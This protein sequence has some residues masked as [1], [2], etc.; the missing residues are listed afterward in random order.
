MLKESTEG[1]NLKSTP[2]KC[3]IVSIQSKVDAFEKMF[4]FDQE[5][6]HSPQI[7][8]CDVDL[9]DDTES[10]LSQNLSIH[11]YII[12]QMDGQ[13]T[14]SSE[15]KVQKKKS[16]FSVN[17]GLNEITQLISFFRSFDNVWN[18]LD[19][20]KI[21]AQNHLLESCFFCYMRSSCLRLNAVR[22]LGPK[23]LKINEFTSQLNQYQ[24]VLGWNWHDHASN[25]PI[26]IQKTLSL[27][28]VYES[29]IPHNLDY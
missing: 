5:I 19:C 28:K 11:D 10:V 8:D 1:S 21:C 13:I 17:I 4:Y 9:S 15:D 12:P 2:N 3:E 20:H 25:L 24:T 16:I 26:F 29:K 27:L 18:S 22:R 23:R 14:E 7:P 6:D